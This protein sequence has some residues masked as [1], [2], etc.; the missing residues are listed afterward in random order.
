MFEAFIFKQK[1]IKSHNLLQKV[2]KST[3]KVDEVDPIYMQ[4]S[5]DRKSESTQTGD[6]QQICMRVNE[7]VDIK[8]IKTDSTIYTEEETES[9]EAY[10]WVYVAEN[11]T[12][13]EAEAEAEAEV[14]NDESTIEENC[15]KTLDEPPDVGTDSIE[16]YD[17]EYCCEQVPHSIQET[18]SKQH[19]DILP[20]I[21]GFMEFFRCSQCLKTFLNTDGLLEHFDAERCERSPELCKEDGCIDYQYLTD[22]TIRLFS[23]YKNADH[24]LSCNLCSLDFENFQTLHNHFSCDHST[25]F[26]SEYL[27][28][29]LAHTCGICGIAFQTLQDCLHHLYFHQSEFVCPQE[30]CEHFANSFATLYYHFTRGHSIESLECS[31]CSYEAKNIFDLKQHQR[32]SCVARSFKCDICGENLIYTQQK[33]IY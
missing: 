8:V 16:T 14:E 10:Q 32:V 2:L 25:S 15:I 4:L 12:E 20:S 26:S 28:P 7:E 5:S 11:E 23:T 24:T 31:Y 9:S 18:H 30:N 13:V 33:T 29:E 22:P 27:H 6:D 1:T 19:T 17:C 21:L 3:Q